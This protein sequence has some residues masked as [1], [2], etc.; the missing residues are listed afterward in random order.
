MKGES[1]EEKRRETG[2]SVC[3][4]DSQS[5]GPVLSAAPLMPKRKFGFAVEITER[6][7]W[8]RERNIL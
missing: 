6:A 5:A 3:D 1:L 7:S 4:C 2:I 8:D